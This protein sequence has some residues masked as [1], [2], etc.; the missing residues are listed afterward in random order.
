MFI[1]SIGSELGQGD[2][3]WIRRRFYEFTPA[4][5]DLKDSVGQLIAKDC[6]TY[7]SAPGRCTGGA[8]KFLASIVVEMLPLIQQ[9]FP[10]GPDQLGL[11][12]ISAGG[13]FASWTVFQA[14][15]PFKKYIISSPAMAY[16][17]DEI[18][19]QEARYAAGHKDLKAE[20]YFGAGGL[21]IQGQPFEAVI[22]T[23]TGM[24]HLAAVLRTRN[25]ASLK[26]FTEVHPGM[27]HADVM[28][29]SV[30]RGL[31]S[32]YGSAQDQQN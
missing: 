26:V 8:P 28:G 24:L 17:N 21:E 16:G 7:H 13:Y 10:I 23:V 27:G 29:T 22:K 11:F 9:K 14:N 19:R 30:V 3:S 18:F 15:S 1:V 25:Y 31:R 5:W 4:D 2:S 20:I 32:L 6:E 12:G